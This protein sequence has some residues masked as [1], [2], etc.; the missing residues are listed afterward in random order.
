MNLERDHGSM[1]MG[2]APVAVGP[3]RRKLGI[4]LIAAVI[5]LGCACQAK[6]TP[7][8]AQAEILGPMRFPHDMHQEQPCVQCHQEAAVGQKGAPRPG[9]NSHAGC[10]ARACHASDFAGE[11]TPLCG[12]CHD[13]LEDGEDQR[14]T[15][16]PYPPA[17]GPRTEAVA[18]SHLLHLDSDRM[19]QRLGFHISCIDCHALP[20]AAGG[21][22]G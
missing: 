4:L 21:T 5:A 22:L 20:S 6:P 7:T 8:S 18:F 3:S 17:A 1:T 16:V 2:R 11:P 12:L 19:E 10:S 15:L 14:T 13:S 9:Q